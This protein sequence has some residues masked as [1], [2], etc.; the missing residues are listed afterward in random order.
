MD[1][2]I[3]KHLWNTTEALEKLGRMTVGRHFLNNDDKEKIAPL[4]PPRILRNTMIF[5][6]QTPPLTTKP[7]ADKLTVG[8]KKVKK[9]T[10]H[11]NTMS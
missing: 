1:A 7:A 2:G 11:T 4:L 5:T 3:P 9:V 6:Y 10:W 8:A